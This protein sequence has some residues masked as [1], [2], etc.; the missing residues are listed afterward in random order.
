LAESSIVGTAIG[1]SLKGY[2]PVVEIQ[3][4]DYIWTAMMQVR[5]EVA[6]IYYRSCGQ[7]SI[8]PVIRTAIGGYIGGG[9]CH[10]QNIE[11]TFAHIPGLYIAYP[12]NAADAK[13]MLKFAMRS[14]NPVLFLE[15][16]GLYRQAFAARPEPDRD[17]VLP[18][19]QAKVVTE[20]KLVTIV[21]YGMMVERAR[22][23]LAQLGAA[24][25]SVEIIDI[26][27]MVPLDTKTILDSVKKTGKVL[28]LHEDAKTGGFGGEIAALI[29]EQAFEYLDAPVRRIGGADTPIP[30][31][32][33]LE[34]E[35]L[36]QVEDIAE[37][38][39]KLLD[40]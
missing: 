14:N 34:R 18:F 1:L 40:Y 5:N 36:P 27:S 20:G 4:G 28:V 3:F 17:Y 12:S 30:F 39:R 9:L 24:D 31:H 32:K 22:E 15:H 25:N 37:G 38:I 8:S 33:N 16:K 35:V 10:S 6:T 29:A 7:F 26:R 2:K 11:A 21:T 23:A 13:G 19:G